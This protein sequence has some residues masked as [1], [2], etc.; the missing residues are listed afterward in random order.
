MTIQGELV[1]ALVPAMKAA[2]TSII[3]REL[4]LTE[5]SLLSTP[6]GKEK[7]FSKQVRGTD[8]AKKIMPGKWG[9]QHPFKGKLVGGE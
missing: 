8:K 6:I 2:A 1:D 7:K 5:S 3:K 9:T 4:G